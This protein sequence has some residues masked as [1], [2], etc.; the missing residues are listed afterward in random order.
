MFQWENIPKYFPKNIDSLV[1]ES[2][3]FWVS[4]VVG[5]GS[6]PEET[7]ITGPSSFVLVICCS[8]IYICLGKCY[9]TKFDPSARIQTNY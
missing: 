8:I 6:S 3:F 1:G 7:N 5:Q 2:V 4:T 9:L